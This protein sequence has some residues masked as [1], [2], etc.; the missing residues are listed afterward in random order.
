M[1]YPLRLLL[2]SLLIGCCC[3]LPRHR[4]L[5]QEDVLVEEVNQAYSTR[6]FADSCWPEGKWWK[7]FHDP[8]LEDLIE[9]AL[10]HNPKMEIAASKIRRAQSEVRLAQSTL[11]PILSGFA[12]IVPQL[13]TRT[14]IFPKNTGIP[15]NYAETDLDL[16]LDWDLDI[17]GK[18]RNQLNSERDLFFAET[19]NART[20]ELLLGIAVAESY[21]TLKVALQIEDL[22]KKIAENRQKKQ[23]L[24]QLRV[25]HKLDNILA[26]LSVK[27]DTLNRV[28]YYEDAKRARELQEHAL[29]TLVATGDPLPCIDQNVPLN[30]FPFPL[31]SRIALDTLS[32][33]PDIQAELW[34]IQS[35]E[36]L[37]KV[38]NAGY[39]PDI[40]I[41]TLIG[42]STIFPAKL[43][44]HE[45]TTYSAG[46]AIH[47]PIFSAGE[48]E[49]KMD[50]AAENFRIEIEQYNA[51][52]L[53]AL[54]EVKD[55]ITSVERFNNEWIAYTQ[56]A[57]ASAEAIHIQK[58]RLKKLSSAL[59]FLDQEEVELLAKSDQIAIEANLLI[60]LLELVKA[61]GG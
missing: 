36:H 45:S 41:S 6:L 3:Q 14:G 49:A 27:Q 11:W 22:A 30:L 34:K 58:I 25:A 56:R 39:Y 32:R 42:L 59:D 38:A 18:N 57:E 2:L 16:N 33:R 50:E 9:S 28:V 23:E 1:F 4:L 26:T 8:C 24:V 21:F 12:D 48:I 35:T 29:Y 7:I 46:P 13:Y 54:Q 60:S 52:I 40:N 5:S 43:F 47:L 20:T 10:F 37:L 51:N 53:Q 15:F 61:V 17:W 44:S 31:P 19:W 55:A